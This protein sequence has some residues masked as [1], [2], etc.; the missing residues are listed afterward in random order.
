M[1]SVCI[2]CFKKPTLSTQP[3][4]PTTAYRHRRDTASFY[5]RNPSETEDAIVNEAKRMD[6][7]DLT[8]LETLAERYQ[9]AVLTDLRV[10]A[11]SFRSTRLLL[12]LEQASLKSPTS[13]QR[14][15]VFRLQRMHQQLLLKLAS[16]KAS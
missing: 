16:V 2:S 5:E 14:H 9:I 10:A 6:N 12:R 13:D 7:E 8:F 15:P 4:A 11:A 1:L 3:L